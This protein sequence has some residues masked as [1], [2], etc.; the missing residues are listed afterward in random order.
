MENS[1]NELGKIIDYLYKNSE[2]IKERMQ[3]EEKYVASLRPII[4]QD[5][6]R[7][8]EAS[9]DNPNLI[10]DFLRDYGDALRLLISGVK[11]KK[12]ENDLRA[13]LEHIESFN[14]EF[15][16][17]IKKEWYISDEEKREAIRKFFETAK[18]KILNNLSQIEEDTKHAANKF[19]SIGI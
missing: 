13:L 4:E 11:I 16:L 1:L 9:F 2:I 8:H 14:Q 15:S 6:N 7:I 12:I 18:E 10:I 3:L 17:N 5:L 19:N